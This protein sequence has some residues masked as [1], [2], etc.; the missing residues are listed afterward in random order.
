MRHDVKGWY[1]GLSSAQRQA[2]RAAALRRHRARRRRALPPATEP[3]SGSPAAEILAA[4]WRRVR[5]T[6]RAQGLL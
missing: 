5:A 6:W 1:Q 4:T 3:E 2:E